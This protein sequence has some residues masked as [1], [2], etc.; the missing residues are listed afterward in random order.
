MMSHASPGRIPARGASSSSMWRQYREPPGRATGAGFGIAAGVTTTVANAAG[1]IMSIYLLAQR[2]PKEDFIAAGVWFFFLV[3]LIYIPLSEEP[4]LA[5]RFG[6]DCLLYKAKVPRW[7]PRWT[8]WEGLS[9]P[10]ELK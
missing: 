6:D 5:K 4:G 8:P 2:L 3:N 7:I 1:P 9:G 10:A